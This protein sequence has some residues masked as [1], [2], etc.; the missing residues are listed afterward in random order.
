[1][2]IKTKQ[3]KKL[4]YL[5]SIKKDNAIMLTDNIN[6]IKARNNDNE[7]ELERDGKIIKLKEKVLWDELYRLGYG[8][9][10][11]KILREKYGDL[12]KM[13]DKDEFLVK[14]INEFTFTNWGFNFNQ[15]TLPILINIIEAVIVWKI[16]RF[17]FL[18]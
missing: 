13:I 2:K 8:C 1:M 6:T 17:F 15:M 9:Q 11:D 10:A 18:D 12:F 5:L 16:K 4:N 3:I 14:E 7:I